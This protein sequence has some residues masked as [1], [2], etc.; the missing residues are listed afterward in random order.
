VVAADPLASR[1]ARDRAQARSQCREDGIELLDHGLV[2]A[3]HHAIASF[4]P[5][6]APA[7]PDI[8]I[9][10]VLGSKVLCAP[11]V[12]DVIRIAV[13]DEDVSRFKMR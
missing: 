6:D 7:C 8:H 13:V 10:N 4:E 12:I 11:D 2:A 5:P 1:S 3:D 9:V